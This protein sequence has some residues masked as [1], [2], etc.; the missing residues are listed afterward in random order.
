VAFFKGEEPYATN[1]RR[2][3]YNALRQG[4]LFDKVYGVDELREAM[5]W[6]TKDFLTPQSRRRLQERLGVQGIFTAD[7]S[8]YKH[9]G[10]GNA[11]IYMDLIDAGSGNKLWSCHAQDDRL[12]SESVSLDETTERAIQNAYKQLQKDLQQQNR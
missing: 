4:A 9:A 8:A 2:N 7:V 1:T 6:S 10:I 5:D 11:H 3:F 12:F